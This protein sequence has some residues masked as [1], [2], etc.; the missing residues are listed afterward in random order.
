MFL[1]GFQKIGETNIVNYLTNVI[2]N[3]HTS[4]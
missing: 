1:F 3:K 4:L 2:E